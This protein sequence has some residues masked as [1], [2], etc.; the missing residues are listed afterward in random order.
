MAKYNGNNEDGNYVKKSPNKDIN[1][2][3]FSGNIGTVQDLREMPSG[4]KVLNFSVALGDDYKNKDGEI[5][6]QT[7]W[8]DLAVFGK[9]AEGLDRIIRKA[10]FVT[11]TAHLKPAHAW[12]DEKTGKARGSNK[13]GLEDLK[14]VTYK[15]DERDPFADDEDGL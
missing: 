11:G 5:V 6:E 4:E 1:L 12:M 13:L 3:A 15:D 14:I 2:F 7:V 8:I 9:R 10:K